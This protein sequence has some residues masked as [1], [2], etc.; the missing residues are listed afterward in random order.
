MKQNL[1]LIGIG[2]LALHL[3]FS[4]PA[5]S[6]TRTFKEV[7]VEING[8]KFWLPSQLTVKKGDKVEIYPISKIPG[9]NPVHGFAIKK[10]GVEVLVNDQGI[11]S[12][13]KDSQGKPQI[14]DKIEFTATE[15]G[16]F[17]MHCQLHPGHVGGQL[18]VLE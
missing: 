15:V 4:V 7:A 12:D 9:Q 2:V 3:S 17:P 13:A 1:I 10:F 18:I 14:K 5:L 6:E 8:T 16:I 11:I